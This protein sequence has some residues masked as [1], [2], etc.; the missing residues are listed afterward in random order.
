V[1]TKQ[2]LEER[3]FLRENEGVAGAESLIRVARHDEEP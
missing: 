2:D 3:A 1:K